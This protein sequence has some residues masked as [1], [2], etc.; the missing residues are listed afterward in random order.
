MTPAK[1]FQQEERINFVM[2]RLKRGFSLVETRRLFESHF[3]CSEG[4]ARKWIND[5]LATEAQ[6]DSVDLRNQY[7]TITI[8][9]FH[10]RILAHQ[11][12]LASINTKLKRIA[13]AESREA[14]IQSLLPSVQGE[15]KATLQQELKELVIPSIDAQLKL[16]S[17][18][19]HTLS[20]IRGE[21]GDLSRIQ[22]VNAT[23]SNWRNALFTL[24]DNN[25]VT[26][27]VAESILT[28]IDDFEQGVRSA[29]EVSAALPDPEDVDD[30]FDE[31]EIVPAT[32]T[33]FAT[34]AATPLPTPENVDD[35][36][37]EIP[38]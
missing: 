7:R 27:G 29:E 34:A 28:M 17:A 18:K 36:L 24:L 11:N 23:Q 22:G 4:T 31:D 33:S 5:A 12:T 16:F 2:S 32:D 15:T 35:L 13:T 26:P 20:L 14:E 19:S 9:A 38:M 6:R 37:D 21:F 3:K 30:L 25:L 1:Q 10:D 8:A